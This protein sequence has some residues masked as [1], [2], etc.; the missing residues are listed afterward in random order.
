MTAKQELMRSRI[1]ASI[2][3]YA[4]A[5]ALDR[6]VLPQ[7]IP[8]YARLPLYAVPY[9]VIGY[10]VLQKACRNLARG[11]AFDEHFLMT[12]ATVAAFV[13]GEYPEAT[14]V[15]LLYQVGELFQSVA[16]GKA[17]ASIS[18][19]MSIEPE[20]ANLETKSGIHTVD[21]DKVEVGSVI[22]V[23]AGER[24]PLDGVVLSGESFVDAS[25]LTGESVPRRV[26]AG[27][28]L[29][30]GSVNGDGLLRVRTTKAYEDSTVAK[31][32]DLVENAS[33]KKARLETFITRFARVYTPAVTIAA[34]L[35]ALV[36][37]LMLSQPFG[38]WVRRACVFL[39]VSCPCALVISVPLGF[40]GGIGAASRIG[41]LVKGGNYL[42]TVA[43][44]DTMVFDKTGTLTR[45]EFKVTKFLPADGVRTDEL[46]LAAVYAESMSNHPIA[47]SVRAIYSD[48]LDMSRLR[49]MSEIGGY[50]IRAVWDRKEL[51]AGSD[52]LLER[53]SV[54][55]T[56]CPEHGTVVYVAHD[57]RY[58]GCFIIAD[59]VKDGSAEAI[60]DL[61][62]AGIR[63]TVMLTG[64]REDLATDIAADL[65]IDKVY[66]ELLPADKVTWL[67][68]LMKRENGK[69]GKVAFVGDGIND[70]PALMRADVGVAMGVLGSDAAIEAADVVLMDDDVRK[71]AAIVRIGR[72]T[73]RVVRENV[74]FALAVKF[75]I[76]ILG[77]LGWASMWLAVFGDVGVTVLAVLN[78]MRCLQAVT[79]KGK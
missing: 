54:K 74:A 14:A 68:S 28:E 46:V 41:V 57:G 5:F 21:P 22:V 39:I 20:Y 13:L 26:T 3:L 27:D 77:T 55:Y 12:V 63:Q 7:S 6:F 31:I 75:L 18:K 69:G 37:P 66:A 40:F 42:E 61:R 52:K 67:E 47:H 59:A 72:R 53:Y 44:C 58:L 78:S 45:G 25:A 62:A 24:V 2:T 73:T 65:G 34:V 8:S 64:D 23:K 32:L 4:A 48:E 1:I 16:V 17:R 43:A 50:G 29:Y 51:L 10:D 76:L 56:P 30:S 60:R 15:M 36:P 38:A 19:M 11:Q 49:N 70:A 79:K 71:L 33:E 35:L 9:L